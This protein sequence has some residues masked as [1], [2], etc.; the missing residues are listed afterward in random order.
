LKMS[1]ENVAGRGLSAR[2]RPAASF[3]EARERAEHFDDAERQSLNPLGRTRLLAGDGLAEDVVVLFHGLTNCVY[4]T[5]DLAAELHA[6]GAAVFIPRLPRHGLADRRKNGLE[7]L[8]A[9][10]LRVCCDAAVDI[11]AGLGKRVTVAGISA[12]GVMA[13][14]CAQFRPEV[15]RATPIAP[16]FA[17]GGRRGVAIETFERAVLLTL[18]NFDLARLDKRAT[19]LDHAYFNFPSRALGQIM[20]LG[21]AVWRAGGRMAPVAREVHVVINAA[22]TAAND[23]VT[24]ALVQRWRRV[25]Y[26]GASV[27]EFAKDHHLIH[28]IIDPS[29][30]QQQTALT[31]PVLLDAILGVRVTTGDAP[32]L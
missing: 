21:Q 24:L 9:E 22:D 20:R 25:G 18:P 11:A 4:Q 3:A 2:P 23:D 30:P 27:Y 15:A 10:E 14:W 6:R 17:F 8:T 19:I 7:R 28:D 12:G 29:Q 31:Y 5:R 16:A 13:A 32:P 1:V 26:T